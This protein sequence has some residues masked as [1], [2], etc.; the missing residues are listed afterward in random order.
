MFHDETKK[1]MCRKN[2]NHE[3]SSL[4]QNSTKP[5]KQSEKALIA[6]K[7]QAI[8]FVATSVIICIF[9]LKCQTT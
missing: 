7:K 1:E 2:V 9:V 5:S 3:F 6:N 4:I 8:I